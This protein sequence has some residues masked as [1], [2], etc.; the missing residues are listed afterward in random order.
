M[1]IVAHRINLINELLEVPAKYGCEIDIRSQDSKL[2]LNHEPY[3]SGDSL[4]DY[5]ALN[6]KLYQQ[7]V[8]GV[9]ENIS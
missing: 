6:F 8:C 9:S 4:V 3:L 7:F 5:L 2:I 1:E